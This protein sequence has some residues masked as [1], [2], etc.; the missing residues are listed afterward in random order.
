MTEELA[1]YR[2]ILEREDREFREAMRVALVPLCFLHLTEKGR[3]P[4]A[5]ILSPILN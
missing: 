4:V 1:K 5:H 2:Q 3:T